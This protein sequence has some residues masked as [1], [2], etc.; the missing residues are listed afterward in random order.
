MPFGNPSS[1]HTEGREARDALEGARSRCASALGVPAGDIYFTS[2]ATESNALVIHSLFFSRFLKTAGDK[3]LILISAIEHPS[4]GENAA[5]L[6]RLGARIGRIGCEED[7]RVTVKTLGK[8]LEKYPG[9]RF[10]AIMAVNNE[11]G[12]VMD[13]PA[14]AALLRSRKGPPVHLHCDM[15]QAAGKIPVNL[16]A[17]DADSASLSA[18]KIG[19]PRGTGL[20]YL[21]RPLD[22]VYAGGG[23][24][25]GVRPGTE[26]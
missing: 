7:G 21:R 24:E 15:V 6:E 26:N 3:T 10:A 23:Q 17:W 14:L 22:P 18:H 2:G 13:M 20:L 4:V 5:R 25:G 12:S 11:T 1:K 9:A 8:A 16:R 19:G